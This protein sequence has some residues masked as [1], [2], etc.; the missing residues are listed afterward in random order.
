M[1]IQPSLAQLNLTS[2]ECHHRMPKPCGGQTGWTKHQWFVISLKKILT[3][4]AHILPLLKGTIIFPSALLFGLGIPKTLVL[5]FML[6][7]SPFLTNTFLAIP[8][9]P[10][11]FSCYSRNAI[12]LLLL[13]PPRQNTFIAI[14]A[15]P[16]TFLA[17]PLSQNTFF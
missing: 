9:T 17:I 5:P 4:F 13:F 10:K 8:I 1:L 11:H 3:V 15:R 7:Q 2:S 12:T 6:H 14:P 16:N